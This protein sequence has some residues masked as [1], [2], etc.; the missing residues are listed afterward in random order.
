MRVSPL[1]RKRRENESLLR[2]LERRYDKGG[3]HHRTL[4]EDLQNIQKLL[5]EQ[6]IDRGHADLLAQRAHHRHLAVQI[7][8]DN[9]RRQVTDYAY[10][11]RTGKL[12]GFLLLVVFVVW[13]FTLTHVFG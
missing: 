11:Q 1:E 5:Q 2:G 4:A 10:H 3:Q 12:V 7:K 6:V 9:A 13:F 8:Q